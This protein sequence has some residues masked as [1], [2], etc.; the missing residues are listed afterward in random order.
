[1]LPGVYLATKKDGT[2][3]YRSS[4]HYQGRHISLGSF[5]KE[6]RA[7]QAYLEAHHV[8]YNLKITIAD[9][10]QMTTILTFE[11]MVSL[12]NFRDHHIYF[13]N[14]IYLKNRFFIYY[15]SKQDELKFDVDDL[16]YYSSHKIMRRNGHLFVN[17][18]GMQVNILSRYGIKNYAVAKKDYLF[19]N[20]DNTDF[21]YSNIIIINRYYGVTKFFKKSIPYYKAKIHI[22]GTVVIGVYT[23]EEKAAIAYNK[24]VDTAKCYG[25]K[26]DFQTNYIIHYSPKEYEDAYANTSIPSTYISYLKKWAN[27]TNS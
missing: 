21:R 3:Y 7:N 8:L 15:I 24:A 22:H 5:D 25:I 14:P 2:A 9:I 12:V 27:T 4:I 13:K 18:Y 20:G 11:K 10:F 17:D 23:T 19:A 6:Q 16:F 1:M 26:K